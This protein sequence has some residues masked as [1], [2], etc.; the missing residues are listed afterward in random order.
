GLLLCAN[1]DGV[2]DR[3]LIS[4]YSN[5]EIIISSKVDRKNYK[6][7]NLDPEITINVNPKQKPYLEWHRT[8]KLQ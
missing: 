7:L 4:F 2:F 3:G 5:G 1:H 8:N 6:L